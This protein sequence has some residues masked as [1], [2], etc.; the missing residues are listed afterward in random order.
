MDNNEQNE[1][2][3]QVDKAQPKEFCRITVVFPLRDDTCALNLRREI[4]KWLVADP[5][6]QITFTIASLPGQFHTDKV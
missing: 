6:A 3:L 1:T 4:A 5:Q 2:T